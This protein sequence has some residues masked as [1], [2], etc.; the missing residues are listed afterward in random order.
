[1]VW[2]VR[3]LVDQRTVAARKLSGIVFVLFGPAR[4]NGR[5]KKNK[6]KNDFKRFG[7]ARVIGRRYGDK[8]KTAVHFHANELAARIIK[9]NIAICKRGSEIHTAM[10]KL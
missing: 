7:A 2:S 1:M 4:G 10:R 9:A 3:R 8:K 6:K 5:L